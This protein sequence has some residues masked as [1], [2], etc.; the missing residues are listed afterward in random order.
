MN[1]FTGIII[2]LIIVLVPLGVGAFFVV[3]A[4]LRGVFRGVSKVGS[5]IAYHGTRAVAGDD[6]ARKHEQTIRGAGAALGVIGGIVA[7]GEVIDIDV[8]GVEDSVAD[9]SIV[10]AGTTGVALSAGADTA[11][12]AAIDLNGNGVVDGYDTDG[13]G[14]IDTNV[15][16]QSMQ[17][18][19]EVDGYVRSDGTEVA[20]HHRTASD[21]STLNN[22][23]PDG[24]REI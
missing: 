16:G 3:R 10:E 4:V 8:D 2:L 1:D 21:G 17:D 14:V 19:T 5:G 20:P 9:G 6:Y 15:V 23:R 18:L 22:L 11:P 7:A 12:G 13:D 24:S